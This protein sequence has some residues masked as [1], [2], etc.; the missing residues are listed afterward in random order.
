MDMVHD[1]IK[2]TICSCGQHLRTGLFD[3]TLVRGDNPEQHLFGIPAAVC[4]AC[5]V[6]VLDPET[7]ALCGLIGSRYR[8]VIESDAR[9]LAEWREGLQAT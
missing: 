1:M 2:S 9:L 7:L 3:V 4:V 5:G 8:F 6:V